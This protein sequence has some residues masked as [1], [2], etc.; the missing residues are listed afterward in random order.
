MVAFKEG[1]KPFDK[2]NGDDEVREELGERGISQTQAG[3][4]AIVVNAIDDIDQDRSRGQADAETI[5]EI[6]FGRT[7]DAD[8]ETIINGKRSLVVEQGDKQ[9]RIADGGCQRHD[10]RGDA[11]HRDEIAVDE[12]G[13]RTGQYSTRYGEPGWQANSLREYPHHYTTKRADSRDR[14]I[15]FTKQQHQ[16]DPQAAKTNLSRLQE[17]IGEVDRIEKEA[18]GNDLEKDD[19]DNKRQKYGEEAQVTAQELAEAA[20]LYIRWRFNSRRVGIFD[21]A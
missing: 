14:E 13:Q 21:G 16:N 19:D 5:G 6:A 8:N 1:H 7:G 17:Q 20:T 4:P 15:D 10:E 12:A 3:A 11:Q 9:A 2:H 18:I